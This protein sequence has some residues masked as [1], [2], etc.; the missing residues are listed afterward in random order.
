MVVGFSY[1]PETSAIYTTQGKFKDVGEVW[2]KVK[3][4]SMAKAS[5]DTGPLMLPVIAKYAIMPFLT[6][7]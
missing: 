4:G 3:Y 1:C 6:V 7:L 2:G 5:E